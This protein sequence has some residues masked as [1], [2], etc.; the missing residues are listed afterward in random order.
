MWFI[1]SLGN[2]MKTSEGDDADDVNAS[3]LI[4]QNKS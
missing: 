3:S 4:Q 1:S 2:N